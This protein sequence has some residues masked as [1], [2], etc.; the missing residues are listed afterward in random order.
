MTL[1]MPGAE[2][3]YFVK[4]RREKLKGSES[5]PFLGLEHRTGGL[6]GTR[7]FE[8]E[9]RW[10]AGVRGACRGQRRS[11]A[12]G[13]PGGQRHREDPAQW[14]RRDRQCQRRRGTRRC[15]PCS[16]PAV[17]AIAP[18]AVGVGARVGEPGRRIPVAAVSREAGPAGGQAGRPPHRDLFGG[19]SRAHLRRRNQKTTPGKAGVTPGGRSPQDCPPLSLSL[20]SSSL[21]PGAPLTAGAAPAAPGLGLSCCPPR[22]EA[23]GHVWG[24]FQGSPCRGA[25]L[26]PWGQRQ[27]PRT[28]GFEW[29]LS[30]RRGLD[31]PAAPGH[32][33]ARTLVPPLSACVLSPLRFQRTLGLL[34]LPAPLVRNCFSSPVPSGPPLLARVSRLLSGPEGCSSGPHQQGGSTR[35]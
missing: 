18:N 19:R 22:G 2:G 14:G 23:S 33:T 10:R 35:H 26:A 20:S 16:L 11:R 30:Q 6:G 27:K 24:C 21:N 12:R 34:L 31:V 1:N 5:E 28:P 25:L 4:V 13:L 9:G 7:A 17:P 32:G 29:H 15:L 3:G 8:V